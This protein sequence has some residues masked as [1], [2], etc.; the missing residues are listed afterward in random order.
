MDANHIVITKMFEKEIKFLQKGSAKRQLVKKRAIVSGGSISKF[1]FV[2]D[3]F[4]REDVPQKKKLEDL[5]FLII[6][7]N[8][9]IQFVEN[10]WLKRL[11]LCLCPK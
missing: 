1:F 9:L 5:G 3:S 10:M 11:I 6:K 7:N 8:L 2:K 4:K